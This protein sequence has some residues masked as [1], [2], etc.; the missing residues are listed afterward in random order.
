MLATLLGCI[1]NM[2][3][4]QDINMLN[5]YKLFQLGVWHNPISISGFYDPLFA[6][7]LV[8]WNGKGVALIIYYR[9]YFAAIQQIDLMISKA[10]N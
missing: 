8:V 3:C 1:F 2:Y 6:T 10:T 5:A 7:S 4:H 9:A